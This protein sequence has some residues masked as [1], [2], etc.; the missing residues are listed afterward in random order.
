MSFKYGGFMPKKP[1]SSQKTKRKILDSA[2]EL[3]AKK[4]FDGISTR[5][6]CKAA[7]VNIS[8]IS[9][10]FGGK[11]ELYSKVVSSIV[12]NII[13]YVMNN[14]GTKELP[15]SFEHLSKEEKIAALFKF[16]DMMMDYFYSDKISDSEIMIIFREQMTSGVPLNAEGYKVLKRLLASIL[17]RDEN[18][19]EIIF[20]T[21]TIVGQI[22]SAKILKQ[23]SLKLMNQSGYSK[24]DIQM[25][26][27]I[28]M[29]QV[30]AILKDLGAV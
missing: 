7:G 23:F 3:F 18:D 25:L 4:G 10:Y 15:Q 9:Y 16:L 11:E 24:Q 2:T 20:R 29:G 13:Q 26:K 14:M 17:G 12:E 27:Q 5:D 30:K 1:D 22:H 6:I 8:M 28:V 21:I 19:K